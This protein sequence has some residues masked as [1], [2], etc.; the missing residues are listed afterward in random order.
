VADLLLDSDILIDAG[1]GVPH[2]ITYLQRHV[3]T[4]TLTISSVSQMELLVGCRN[5]TEQRQLERFLRQFSV[6][7][8]NEAIA[9]QAVALIRQYRLSHGLAMPDAL[10]AATALTNTIP[11]ATGNQRDFRFSAGLQLVPY[12]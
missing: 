12:P 10:I 5:K 8:L 9:D 11:L 4:F 6:L 1:R 7:K 2:A 3:T